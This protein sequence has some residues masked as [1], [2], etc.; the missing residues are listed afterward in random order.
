MY[1]KLKGQNVKLEKAKET[2]GDDFF[3][4]LKEVE[5]GVMLDYTLFGYFDRCRQIN[6]ILSKE[7]YFL[8]FYERRNKFRFQLKKKLHNKNEMRCELSSCAILLE[9]EKTALTA[10]PRLDFL[11]TILLQKPKIVSV[12]CAKFDRNT[13]FLYKEQRQKSILGFI[14]C[15]GWKE[16]LTPAGSTFTTES[17]KE[18]FS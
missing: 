15:A 9:L 3:L 2:L 16:K 18:T 4:K 10:T 5:S 1:D 14:L 17:F 11:N 8:R 12:D 7:Y 13:L 6:D